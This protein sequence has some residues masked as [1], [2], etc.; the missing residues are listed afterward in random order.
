MNPRYR[1]LLEETRAA[2]DGIVDAT[3]YKMQIRVDD[4][5]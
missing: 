2:E 1:S 4:E 5:D 3:R